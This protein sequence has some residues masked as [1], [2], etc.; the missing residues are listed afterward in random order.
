MLVRFRAVGVIE[1]EPMMHEFLREPS[2]LHACNFFFF[3]ISLFIISSIH[4]SYHLPLSPLP[5]PAFLG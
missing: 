4:P 5:T 1:F 2:A 3:S